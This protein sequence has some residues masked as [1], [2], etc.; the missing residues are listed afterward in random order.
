MKITNGWS[1]G[2]ITDGYHQSRIIKIVKSVISQKI[3]NFEIIII[4]DKKEKYNFKFNNNAIS[5]FDFENLGEWSNNNKDK[6]FPIS[7]KKN[8]IIDKAK[9]EKICFLHD[10][11]CLDQNWYSGILKFET[12]NEWKILTNRILNKDNTR[13]FDWVLYDQPITYKKV[14]FLPEDK[15][16]NHYQYIPGYYWCAK[17]EVM[18]KFKLNEILKWGEKED[19]E[20]SMRVRKIYK[21]SFNKFSSVRFLKYKDGPWSKKHPKYKKVMLRSYF[22][23]FL[24]IFKFLR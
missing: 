19:V 11:V 4:G 22:I 24:F 18:S 15:N 6:T 8:L 16:I 13:V 10:Y 12:K 9:F 14:T 3:P 17:K 20:W 7:L 2:V 21:F 1:F 5:I 23:K